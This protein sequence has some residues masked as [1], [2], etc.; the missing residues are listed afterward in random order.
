MILFGTDGIRGRYG[1]FPLDDS[2]IKKI[3]CSIA[4]SFGNTVKKVIIGHDGRESCGAILDSLTDGINFI[5]NY[6][7]INLDLFPTPSLPL[8]LSKND[9]EDAIGIEITA[10]HNPYLDNGI[11]IFNKN[12]YKISSEL[13]RKIEEIVATQNDV[14][15]T[16]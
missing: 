16:S 5:N 9:S 3:G 14:N 6:D 1:D 10:S 4:K 12:G 13:E 15:K 7:I 8:I 2:T 11:K